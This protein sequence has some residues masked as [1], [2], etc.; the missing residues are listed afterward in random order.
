MSAASTPVARAETLLSA[1]VLAFALIVIGVL[2]FIFPPTVAS[3]IQQRRVTR[4]VTQVQALA[5]AI[6]ADAASKLSTRPE[7]VDVELLIGP[8]DAVIEAGDRAW[9][10]SRAAPLRASVAAPDTIL[11]PDPWLRA[12]LVNIGARKRGGPIWVL[13]AGPNGI[14]E[15]P[16]LSSAPA[17]DDVAVRVP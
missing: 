17:G 3:W 7:L 12:L 15:T 5:Q 9:I 1:R 8:G 6:A 16:F 2:A 14:V 11:A 13:S 4:A 10:D